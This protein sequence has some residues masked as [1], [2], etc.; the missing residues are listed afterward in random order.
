[1][2]GLS[3]IQTLAGVGHVGCDSTNSTMV[4][5]DAKLWYR[6]LASF[7]NEGSSKKT[8]VEDRGQLSHVLTPPP[9]PVKLGE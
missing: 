9:L 8:G 2:L 3:N 4:T 1:M 5:P 6:C 7:R